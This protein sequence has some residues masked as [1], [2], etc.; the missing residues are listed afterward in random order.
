MAAQSDK[1]HVFAALHEAPETF[2]IANAWD[3]GSACILAALGFKALAT[4]SA[5]F[6]RSIGRTDYQAG[7][8]AV[9]A[10]VRALA[11]AVVK[12]KDPLPQAAAARSAAAP[13]AAK[14]PAASASA[15]TPCAVRVPRSRHPCPVPICSS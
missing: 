4:T 12:A 14:C 9:I 13:A 8:E 10:H 15:G 6:A 5:G 3:P 7:R 1:A 11:A 2:V